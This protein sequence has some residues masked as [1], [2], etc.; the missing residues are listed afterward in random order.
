MD[1]CNTRYASA[2]IAVL[3]IIGCVAVLL[4]FIGTLLF[5]AI[6]CIT[7]W[8]AYTRLLRLCRGRSSLAA[9]ISA[10]LLVLLVLLPMGILAGAL[11]NGVE[12]ALAFAKPLIDGG[13]PADAPAW[14]T[15]IPVVGH[16]IGAYWH[17]LAASREEFN[18]LLQMG[19]DPARR[20]A[21]MMVTM[22]GQGLLQIVLVIF[23]VFF[24]FRD[25]ENYG[26]A[27]LVAA[28]KLAGDLGERMLRLAGATVTGVMY[29]LVGTAAGQAF[30]GMIGYLLAGVPGVMMLTFATFIF[31][32][33][34]IIGATLIWGGAAVWLYY[35]GQT[36]WAIFLA[37]WGTF[38]LSS[39]DNFLR[40]IL[41]S[42]TSS[43]PLLLI[44]VGVFGGMTVFGFIGLFLGPTLLALGQALLR[45]WIKDSLP[46]KEVEA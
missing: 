27:L 22:F 25:A 16:E 12:F 42:R 37:L 21:L 23:F 41:I 6:I 46:A 32:M 20:L 5:A 43:L 24:I 29:G 10:L 33:V 3:L 9:L 13:L 4:P 11:A 26:E 17:K 1:Q 8:P 40:P 7:T 2:A 34:P 44:I 31:S 15:G 38:A 39:V 19:F 30:V 36:G 14:L 45:D 28:R 35:T 18:K